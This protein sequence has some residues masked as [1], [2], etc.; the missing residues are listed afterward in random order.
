[1]IAKQIQ[2]LRASRLGALL[3]IGLWC[4]TLTAQA[5]QAPQQL[6]ED[7]VAGHDDLAEAELALSNGDLET[8]CPVFENTSC[9]GRSNS[10][11]VEQPARKRLWHLR[12]TLLFDV[13]TSTPFP[14]I[15]GLYKGGFYV[16][17]AS[18]LLCSWG[19]LRNRLRLENLRKS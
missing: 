13:E 4:V 6:I 14:R 17:V 7:N 15:S 3:L 9:P 12:N 2:C 16:N 5:Q 11:S 1:M 19:P 8:A 10:I 18:R